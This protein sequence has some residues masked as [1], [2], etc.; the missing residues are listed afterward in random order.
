MPPMGCNQI[1]IAHSFPEGIGLGQIQDMGTVII[2]PRG[3]NNGYD[4]IANLSLMEMLDQWFDERTEDL[5][6][7]QYK[8]VLGKGLKLSSE[9]LAK[10]VYSS[11][12]RLTFI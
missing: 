1:I 6:D 4:I 10:N 2:R 5:D 7:K 3:Y 12:V 9:I 11:G 8:V